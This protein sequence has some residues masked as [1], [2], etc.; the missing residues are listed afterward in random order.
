MPIP[1]VTIQHDEKTGQI[2]FS[3][4]PQTE[5]DRLVLS[6]LLYRAILALN[7]MPLQKPGIETTPAAL[8]EMFKRRNGNADR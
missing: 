8:A 7:A 2:G 5:I 6:G 3:V 4:T 1:P